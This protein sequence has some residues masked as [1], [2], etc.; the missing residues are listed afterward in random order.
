MD[1]LISCPIFARQR[2]IVAST[3][4]VIHE[5]IA[6]RGTYQQLMVCLRAALSRHT[7]PSWPT[8]RLKLWQIASH[9]RAWLL[10]MS[11]HDLSFVDAVLYHVNHSAM[12][13]SAILQF[14]AAWPE[15]YP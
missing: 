7:E 10:S 1:L 9:V 3:G 13:D 6:M 12:D 14:L 2:F 11:F 5:P 8:G 4:M 15:V